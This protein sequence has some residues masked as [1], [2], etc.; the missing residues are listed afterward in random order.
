MFIPFR[1]AVRQL[2]LAEGCQINAVS[3]AEPITESFA[4]VVVIPRVER[5]I[6]ALVPSHPH[7]R[8]TQEVTVIVTKRTVDVERNNGL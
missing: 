3:S 4:T 6:M 1:Q 5:R 7:F 2:Y 8:E